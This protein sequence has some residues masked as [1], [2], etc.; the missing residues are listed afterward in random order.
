MAGGTILD[1]RTLGLQRRV[2]HIYLQVTRIEV[3]FEG[4]GKAEGGKESLWGSRREGRIATTVLDLDLS[5]KDV[6]GEIGASEI[7]GDIDHLC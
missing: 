2:R 5:F 1:S 6:G 7:S 3:F 4:A